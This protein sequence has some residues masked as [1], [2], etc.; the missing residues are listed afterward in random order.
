MK[1][2]YPRNKLR[3]NDGRNF[4]LIELLVVIAIIAILSAM[5]LPALKN[6]RETAKAS[7]CRSNQKQISLAVIGYNNDF[8]GY[9]PPWKYSNANDLYWNCILQR[10]DYIT[11]TELYQCPT[12]STILLNNYTFGIN[13]CVQKPA[14]RSAY[15]YTC[16]GYNSMHV[17]GA[18]AGTTWL[19]DGDQYIPA[20]TV[21]FRKPTETICLADARNRHDASDDRGASVLSDDV[22]TNG[23]AIHDL[24]Q[25]GAN[26]LWGDGHVSAEKNAWQRLSGRTDK[27]YFMRDPDGLY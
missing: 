12:A 26:V 22:L 25:G 11:Q 24:H 13:D 17:G 7:N 3:N 20:R 6:A 27:Y 1:R 21:Q 19:L 15:Y 4:T 2:L 8:D 18:R 5:L 23:Q 10:Q 16:Y 14:Y 9:F